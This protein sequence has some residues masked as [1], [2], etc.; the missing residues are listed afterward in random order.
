M[1]GSSVRHDEEEGL[2][3]RE[4][5]GPPGKANGPGNRAC[6]ECHRLKMKCIKD[7]DNE[8]CTRCRQGN[9]HC[10]FD[11][12]R[13][14]K[15]S[16]VEER[17]RLV[18][19]Q[20]GSMQGNLEELLRLQRGAVGV[21]GPS[22]HDPRSAPPMTYSTTADDLST[23]PNT[24]VSFGSRLDFPRPNPSPM[25]SADPIRSSYSDVQATPN[26]PQLPQFAPP[27]PSAQPTWQSNSSAHQ[28]PPAAASP[29]DASDDEEALDPFAS[30]QAAAP[31]G[32][33]LS[34]AEA[35]RLKADSHIA[36]DDDPTDTLRRRQSGLSHWEEEDPSGRP[37]KRARAMSRVAASP[38][39]LMIN[40]K[41]NHVFPDP[42]HLGWC[43]EERARQ[44]YDLF[45]ER[46]QFYIPCFDPGYDTW[47]SL[48]KR[49]PFVI[50]T[51]MLVALKCQEAGGT[52]SELQMRCREHAERIAMSTLFTPVARNELVQGMILLASW[53]ETFWRP[54]G[55]AVRM[56]LDL[57]LYRCMSHLV[58]SGMGAGKTAQ[59]LEAERP[60]VVGARIWLTL[61]KSEYE[62]SFAYGRPVMFLAQDLPVKDAR[63]LLDHPLS[64]PTDIRLVSTCESLSYRLPLHQPFALAPTNVADPIP[65]MDEKLRNLNRGLDEWYDYWDDYCARQGFRPDHLLRE[66]LITGRAGTLLG[67]N[68]YVL[69]GIR[70]GRDVTNMSEERRRWL[71]DA[72]RAAQQLVSK[73]LRG[74][75]YKQNFQY[76]YNVAYSSRFLI[77]VASLV[78]ESCN[79]RQVGRDVEEVSAMLATVPGFQFAQF[80]RD[81]M[82][83]ARRDHVLP[84]SSRAP[85]RAPSRH[86]SPSRGLSKLPPD[87]LS[88]PHTSWT[89]EPAPT[90][91]SLPV[92][93]LGTGFDSSSDT[94]LSSHLD[95]L[96]AEQLFANTG[97]G[98]NAG[99]IM[100][101]TALSSASANNQQNFDQDLAAGGGMDQSFNNLDS[102][103]P[104]P[105]LES[106][107]SPGVPIPPP[108]GGVPAR[109]AADKPA[110]WL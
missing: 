59:E 108:A 74:Q 76:D 101:S 57:G 83:R 33:M 106:E 97:L 41:G 88:A 27:G 78:P 21:P 55:H 34:L 3:D 89:N 109:V 46:C 49:S 42:I 22:S 17:L 82:R 75:Q 47:E 107:T 84:P 68:S 31:W 110:W 58:E 19:A 37:R 51:V 99:Q 54:G 60:V 25:A 93:G 50:T 103:F 104:F 102:W 61:F 7:K 8:P 66:T 81:V 52:P 80:L 44:L 10:T 98:Q 87:P 72:G 18:E 100:V 28:P 40:E 20:I 48:R 56:A 63:R 13:K 14:S 15:Q 11:G 45:F 86:A 79:L 35:A 105:A 85:S 30:D 1:A 71:L 23:T 62:M 2:D 90:G 38:M 95:F 5:S 64:L 73:C 69:H 53:G 9:R 91:M 43:S 77:R 32:S 92:P 67:S 6:D 94:G 36:R 4:T 70:K 39:E 12:P 96:Y 65:D 24:I 29:G 26:N 16:K